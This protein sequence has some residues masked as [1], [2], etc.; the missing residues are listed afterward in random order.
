MF[1]G[2][3]MAVVFLIFINTQQVKIDDVNEFREVTFGVSQGTV[4]GPI[5]FSFYINWLL[6]RKIGHTVISLIDDTAVL[7]K[8][9]LG[10]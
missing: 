9:K 5:M 8:K 3:I 1:S 4:L 10:I 7:Y 6:K 2:K